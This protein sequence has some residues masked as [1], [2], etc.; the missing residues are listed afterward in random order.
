MARRHSREPVAGATPFDVSCG[1]DRVIIGSSRS[2]SGAASLSTAIEIPPGDA[3][4]K[5][6]TQEL[7]SRPG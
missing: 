7:C 2:R 6:V 5:A 3:F 1:N 4:N